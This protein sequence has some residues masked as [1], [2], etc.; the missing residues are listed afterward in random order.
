MH[1]S[2][3]SLLGTPVTARDL[4][5]GALL[6]PVAVRDFN[7][8]L[9]TIEDLPPQDTVRWVIRR[10]ATVLAAVRGR[11]LSQEEARERY[12]LSED[13]FALWEAQVRRGGIPALRATR[14]DENWIQRVSPEGVG[15][16]SFED[17]EAT[18][19]FADITFPKVSSKGG[20]MLN[21][22][23][24][25]VHLTRREAELLTLL[26]QNRDSTLDKEKTLFLLYG[27]DER[28]E[29]KILDVF[30]CKLRKKL[31]AVSLSSRIETVWG[32]GYR[33]VM[34]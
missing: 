17:P 5:T 1:D 23:M 26:I 25:S 18:L 4:R 28:P 30:V 7:G 31:R 11:L 14:V 12:S 27:N 3:K 22:E 13:E 24:G 2:Q 6:Q 16:G 20:V 8:E 10:K 19:A 34:S 21:G 9:I 32:R 15:N 29:Q 33:I